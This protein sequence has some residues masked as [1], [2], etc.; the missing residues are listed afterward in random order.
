[1]IVRLLKMCLRYNVIITKIGSNVNQDSFSRD[2]TRIKP[3]SSD[4]G[5]NMCGCDFILLCNLTRLGIKA[6][7]KITSKLVTKLENN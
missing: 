4:D 7:W 6:G 2:R 1:M 3:E 5:A